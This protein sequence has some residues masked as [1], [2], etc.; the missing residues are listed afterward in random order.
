MEVVRGDRVRSGREEA[1][2]GRTGSR[3]EAVPVD[4]R[5]R[6]E[7]PLEELAHRPEGQ[8]LL[9]LGAASAWGRQPALVRALDG[10]GYQRA[11]TGA[12]RPLDHDQPPLPP[13][14]PREG[15]RQLRELVLALEQP[16]ARDTKRQSERRIG[17]GSAP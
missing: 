13:A 17:R 4:V 9:E 3:E 14:R 1:C 5:N 2:R 11:L 12:R 16:H 7:R 8:L 15:G 6:R 10:G